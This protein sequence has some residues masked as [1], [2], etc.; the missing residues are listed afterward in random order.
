MA[1]GTD[2]VSGTRDYTRRWGAISTGEVVADPERRLLSRQE[3]VDALLADTAGPGPAGHGFEASDDVSLGANF[4][5][6]A[7]AGLLRV[8]NLDTNDDT[9]GSNG[10]VH[11]A[12]VDGFLVPALDRARADGVLVLL[13]SHHATTNIDV[14]RG[15]LS[16][17]V[18]DDAVPPEE[19]ETLV[20]SYDNVVAWLVG[21]NHLNRVRA[22]AGPDAARPGYWEIMTS[23]MSDYP[24]QARVL[25]IVDN[26]DSTLSLLG[27]LVDFD[28]DHCEERR[29]RRLL[30]M[31]HLSGWGDPAN[32]DAQNLNVELVRPTPASASAAVA[33][34]TPADRIDSETTLRGE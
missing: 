20:A 5:Y 10:L 30:L 26:G 6:D 25:E 27:T 21:H 18:V 12:T 8:I 7:I 4:E 14:F 24:G 22:I 17:T 29:Y 33:A 34:A 23:A 32:F 31:E 13:A 16:S 11:R 1:V 2:P 28:E 15:Q 9:G 3:I 19:L